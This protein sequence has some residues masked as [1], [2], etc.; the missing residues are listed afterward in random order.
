MTRC[1]RSN[2]R[3][4]QGWV[5][6]WFFNSLLVHKHLQRPGNERAIPCPLSQRIGLIVC[7]QLDRKVLVG[8]SE[9]H[10]EVLVCQLRRHHIE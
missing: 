3:F 1:N 8:V 10:Q 4:S 9:L 6:A 7:I 5:G 2:V